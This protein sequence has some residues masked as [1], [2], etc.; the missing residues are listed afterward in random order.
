MIK[1]SR[2]YSLICLVLALSLLLLFLIYWINRYQNENM[3][4]DVISNFWSE[5]ENETK[6]KVVELSSASD[7]SSEIPIIYRIY[8]YV[9][10]VFDGNDY[11]PIENQLRSYSF[12][13]DSKEKNF[14]FIAKTIKN[15]VF[16]V[17]I[18]HDDCSLKKEINEWTNY[19]VSNLPELEGML[20]S[21]CRGRRN[22]P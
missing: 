5:M 1:K 7:I 8:I 17:E 22:A 20:N 2:A 14:Y 4:V 15:R 21:K 12:L 16:K 10:S 19:L 11:P 3:Q 9:L 13:I 6:Y 18:I